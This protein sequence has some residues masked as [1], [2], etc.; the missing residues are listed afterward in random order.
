MAEPERARGRTDPVGGAGRMPCGPRVGSRR[1]GSKVDHRRIGRLQEILIGMRIDRHDAERASRRGRDRVVLGPGG[2]GL[3]QRFGRGRAGDVPVDRQPVVVQHVDECDILGRGAEQREIA[4]QQRHRLAH[5]FGRRTASALRVLAEQQV[6]PREKAL[7]LGCAA[8][9]QCAHARGG[10]PPEIV[11]IVAGERGQH[12]I[13]FVECR[14]GRAVF[15]AQHAEQRLFVAGTNPGRERIGQRPQRGRRH[16]ATD[17]RER[18]ERRMRAQ[19]GG[20]LRTQC[21]EMV[22]E[23]G[24]AGELAQIVAR[25][26]RAEIAQRGTPADRSRFSGDERNGGRQLPRETRGRQPAGFRQHGRRS[27]ERRGCIVAMLESVGGRRKPCVGRTHGPAARVGQCV[28][29]G[30]VR[31]FWPHGHARLSSSSRSREPRR[32]SAGSMRGLSGVSVGQRSG[33]I[34]TISKSSLRAPHSGHVQLIGTSS[35]RVPGAMP[36]SGSPASSS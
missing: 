32:A 22:E 12:R 3:P 7:Q 14:I 8:G 19:V 17:E 29:V 26:R 1:I 25:D 34:W 6:R 13:E 36:S 30:N 16:R 15:R 10:K 20:A 33:Q 27:G 18:V 24:R 4:P 2:I 5:E 11:W 35:Q 28:R 21:T 9:A 31:R 23:N